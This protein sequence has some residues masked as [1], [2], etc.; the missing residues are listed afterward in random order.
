MTNTKK[1]LGCRMRPREHKNV[2]LVS[3]REDTSMSDF[4]TEAFHAWLEKC[5]H[6]EAEYRAQPPNCEAKT[7]SLT[8]PCALATA[9]QAQARADDEN[10]TDAYY[11][12]VTIYMEAYAQNSCLPSRRTLGLP[13]KAAS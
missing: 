6:G 10:L 8:V 2:R 5:E 1:T 3:L 7:V 11:S 13:A 12:A 4:F 9:V